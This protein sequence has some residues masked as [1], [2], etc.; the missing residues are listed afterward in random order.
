MD[1][2]IFTSLS[3]QNTVAHRMQQIS[4]EIANV[5]TT[6]FKRSFAAA[7]KTYRYEGEGF[8]SRFVPVLTPATGVDMTPGNVMNT[9]RPLD[10]AIGGT[11][12]MAVQA[13]DGSV[14]YTRR[15]DLNIDASGTLRTG[16]GE[17][18]LDDGG[19]PVQIPGL[20]EVKVGTDGTIFT[21]TPGEQAAVFLPFGRIQIVDPPVEQIQLRTDGLYKNASGEAFALAETP[22]VQSGALEGSNTNLFSTMVDMISMS[23]RYE[24]QVKVIKQ[25]NDLA[26]RSQ[27]LARLNQ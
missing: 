18:V 22:S 8:S 11:Q 13:A 17:A 24:M 19:A 1:R 15:G 23:R 2:L 10:V 5:S 16:S 3:G 25:A 4:N 20:V 12:L 26:E 27:S 14:A 21:K 7:I 6:G 9:G